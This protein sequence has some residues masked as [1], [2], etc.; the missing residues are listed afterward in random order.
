MAKRRQIY[1]IE[2]RQGELGNEWKTIF[3]VLLRFLLDW[4]DAEVESNSFF[5]KIVFFFN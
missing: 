5:A 2:I 3:G 4:A 1:D